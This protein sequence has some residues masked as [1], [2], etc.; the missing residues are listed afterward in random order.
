MPPRVSVLMAVYNGE[1]YLR[2]AVDSILAQT[3][4]DFEFLIIDDGSTDGGGAILADYTARDPRIRLVTHTANRGLTASLNEGL[5]LAEGEY[6]ARMDADDISLPERFEQQVAFLDQ[7]P[8]I[9]VAGGWFQLM[10]ADGRLVLPIYERPLLPALVAW[11]LFFYNPIAHPTVMMRRRT[12]LQFGGY[13]P[14]IARSQDHELWCRLASHTQLTNIAR[15]LT[16][17]RKHDDNISLQDCGEGL[18]G[19]LRA[20]ARFSQ[21]T[22]GRAESEAV[23]RSLYTRQYATRRQGFQVAVLI[24][25][26]AQAAVR[27][28]PSDLGA[29]RLI[30]QDAARRLKEIALPWPSSSL[31]WRRWLVLRWARDLERGQ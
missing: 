14:T 21:Q 26:L 31:S 12:V 5:Q 6:V 11:D 7:A 18:T 19:S 13:D 9:S 24:R 10:D 2:A 23:L 3:Y 22:L 17:I 8:H 30:R 1:R 20:L 25:K 29:S 15:L 16:Y 4:T 27:N 28:P